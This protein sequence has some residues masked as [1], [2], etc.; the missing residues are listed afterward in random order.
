MSCE[1]GAGLSA[2]EWLTLCTCM[3]SGLHLAMLLLAERKQ[4]SPPMVGKY[5]A[6]PWHHGLTGHKSELILKL[7][8]ATIVSFPG[9]VQ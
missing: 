9:S 4:P 7:N 6:Q 8:M 5:E 3:L 1:T 2:D